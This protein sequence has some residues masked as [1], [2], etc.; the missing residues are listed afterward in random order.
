MLFYYETF[1]EQGAA[2]PAQAVDGLLFAM[3][4]VP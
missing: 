2:P 1:V 3:D 4:L